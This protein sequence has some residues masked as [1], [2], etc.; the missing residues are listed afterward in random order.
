MPAIHSSIIRVRVASF[1]LLLAGTGV[2]MAAP[3]LDQN[4][5]DRRFGSMSGRAVLA[6][7]QGGD[8]ADEGFAVGEQSDGKLVVAGRVA[9]AGGRSGIGVSRVLRN[10][11]ADSAFGNQARFVYVPDANVSS[12]AYAL[13]VQSDDKV[14]IAGWI[15]GPSFQGQDFLVIR[16]NANGSLDTGFGASG[17]TV[18]SFDRGG[19]FSDWATAVAIQDDGRIVVA[20][21]VQ[22]AGTNDR[23]IGIARLSGSGLFDMSFGSSGTQIVAPDHGG[24]DDDRASSVAIQDDGKVLVGGWS[25]TQDRG[26]DMLLIRLTANGAEDVAF[27]AHQGHQLVHLPIGSCLDDEAAVLKVVEWPQF[28]PAGTQRRYMLAGSTCRD[29]SGSANDW[30]YAVARLLENGSFDTTLSGQGWRAVAMDLGGINRDMGTGLVFHSDTLY[31]L[32]GPPSHFLVGGFALDTRPPGDRGY[33]FGVRMVRW[34]GDTEERFGAEGKIYVDFDLGGNNHDLANGMIKTSDRQLVMAG[35]I[36]RLQG[37][38][39]DFGITRI[40]LDRIFAGSQDND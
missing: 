1:C 17:R 40:I 14:V 30:D 28:V 39:T 38:D 6:F 4:A 29:V 21:N 15:T 10:G 27:G 26:K 11:Q 5:I 24:G 3:E 32:V 33:Q 37:N 23:D 25:T 22:R 2:L 7:D 35:T 12:G 19:N 31:S 16:L 36:K 34:N 18:I 8:W 20:G 13:A 9:L